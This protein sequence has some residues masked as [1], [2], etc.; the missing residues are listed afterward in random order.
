MTK[1]VRTWIVLLALVGLLAA[2]VS[3]FVHLELLRDPGYTSFCDLNANVSCTRVYESRFASVRGVP[4]AVGGVFWF[5]GVLLLVLADARGAQES[6][7]NVA[8]YLIVWSTA[9]LA[10]AM[11]MAFASYVVLQ[12]FCVLCSVVHVTVVG[13]FLVADT[14]SVVRLSRVPRALVQDLGRLVGRPVG[15]AVTVAFLGAAVATVI[16]VP[17]PRPQTAGHAETPATSIE[18]RVEFDRWW[19]GQLR[20]DSPV[21]IADATVV[22]VKFNDYQCPACAQTHL[23]YESVF[24]KYASSHP[25]QVRLVVMDYPL[26]PECNDQTPNGPHDSAC[27]AAVAVRLARLVGEDAANRMERWLYANQDTMTP[28]TVAV[29]AADIAGVEEF[30]ARYSATLDQVRS[31]IAVAAALPVEATPTFVINGVLLKGGLTTEFFD[32]AIAYELERRSD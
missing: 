28:H 23:T 16:W 18:R 32:R 15:L 3:S 30:D 10:V 1:P 12:T 26:D 19:A 9:G 7:E 17:R 21:E 4:V 22:V 27:E 14:G 20:V 13:I 29:A 24:A 31:D 25:G 11:Y 5:V 6:R 8:A 2:A